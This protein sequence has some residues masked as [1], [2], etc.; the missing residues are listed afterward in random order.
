[1]RIMLLALFFVAGILFFGYYHEYIIINFKKT[2]ASTFDQTPT[3]QKKKIPLH[4]W[5]DGWR[6]EEIQ[7]LLSDS[8]VAN[9][10]IIAS[11]WLEMA[12]DEHLL[13]K[14]VAVESV[15][16]HSDELFISLERAPF[17]KESSTFEKWMIVESILKTLKSAGLPF[18]NVRF[19]VHHQPMQDVHL[20]FSLAWPINGFVTEK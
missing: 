14:R 5:R 20:E 10:Q 6:T 1:M 15:L 11:S 16:A 9:A 19:L 2:T 3:A 4:F 12:H 8:A 7:L 17:A 13:K 18:K